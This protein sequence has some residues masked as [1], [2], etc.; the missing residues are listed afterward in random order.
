M[1]ENANMKVVVIG[2]TGL[3]GSKVVKILGERGY[4]VVAASPNSG[5][6]SLTG[7]GLAEVLAGTSVVID[8]SNSP[9]FADDAVMEF[10]TTSTRNLLSYEA[11]AGVGHHVALSIVGCDGLPDSGYMRAKVAQE[12][13]IEESSI[14]FSIVRATQFFEF[15]KGIADSATEGNTVRLPAVEFQPLAADDVASVVAKIAIG[16]P[17]NA[18]VE[19]AGPEQFRFN[20]FISRGLRARH[21]PREVIADPNARYFG[22]ELSE[23]S[24]VPG[25]DAM[26]G[27]IR[28]E[29]WLTGA[30]SQP[31][32]EQR[33]NTAGASS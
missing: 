5:V 11:A 19:V 22:A 1:T 33:H 32:P 6:N 8:L 15:L 23:R 26:L 4:E 24:L 20:E 30:G 13:L 14:P 16:S 25:G 21:D 29:D 10:F 2:G 27:E 17:L 28:F 18:I 9:N 31:P 7:E 3:I 12:K